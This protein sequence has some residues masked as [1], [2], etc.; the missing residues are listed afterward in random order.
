MPGY[1]EW[2]FRDPRIVAIA[3]YLYRGDNK[4]MPA[5]CMQNGG[6]SVWDWMDVGFSD[7]PQ[8]LAAW[9]KTGREIVGEKTF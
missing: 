8:T 7:L 6:A 2:A 4:T 3:P 9:Q 1:T 5:P